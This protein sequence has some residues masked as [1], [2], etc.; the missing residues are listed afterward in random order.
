MCKLL[1]IIEPII[2]SCEIV[3]VTPLL[4]PGRKPLDAKN[5]FLPEFFSTDH[6]LCNNFESL[7]ISCWKRFQ[8]Q[9]FESKRLLE[10][11]HQVVLSLSETYHHGS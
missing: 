6:V 1:F 9:K 2:K 8:D 10:N 7:N 3:H 5:H 4:T 11:F